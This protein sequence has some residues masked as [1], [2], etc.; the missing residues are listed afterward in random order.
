MK[1]ETTKN[2]IKKY[3]AGTS[4][5]EEERQ[6]FDSTHESEAKIEA[7]SHFVKQNKIE[8][9]EGFNDTLWDSFEKKNNRTRKL[10]FGILSA[11]A[12]VLLIITLFISYPTQ[13]ELSYS[14]K[15]ALLTESLNMFANTNEVKRE[16]T[17]I[18]ESDLIIIYNSI[19]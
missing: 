11:A 8:I 5:L 9:P 7:L 12:S 18:Y 19:E 13:Q 16:H 10:K 17:I 3:E 2:L 1:K 14:E 6:L 15:E 4:T